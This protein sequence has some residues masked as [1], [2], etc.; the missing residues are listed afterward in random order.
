MGEIANPALA[1]IRNQL[2]SSMP[3]L[4]AKADAWSARNDLRNYTG[5]LHQIAALVPDF[6][7][8]SLA[9]RDFGIAHASGIQNDTSHLDV[10]LLACRSRCWPA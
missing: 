3:E 9:K 8:R 10:V 2:H 5:S 1:G 6:D 7:R 4:R